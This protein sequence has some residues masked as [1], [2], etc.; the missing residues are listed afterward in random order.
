MGATRPLPPSTREHPELFMNA[1]LDIL[2]FALAY[3][4]G[5]LTVL[6]IMDRKLHPR[7]KVRKVTD[8][9]PIGL[10]MHS[11]LTPDGARLA[12][13]KEYRMNDDGLEAVTDGGNTIKI[14]RDE[15]NEYDYQVMKE[16][17]Q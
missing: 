3:I 11:Y 17:A 15:M 1:V 12:K 13:I 5:G 14:N 10:K 9:D 6:Y 7:R 8:T 2:A 16:L 4:M